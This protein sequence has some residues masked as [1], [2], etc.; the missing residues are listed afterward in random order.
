MRQGPTSMHLEIVTFN[1]WKMSNLKYNN[2]VSIKLLVKNADSEP[3]CILFSQLH[4][5]LI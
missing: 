3:H 2:K 4:I 1:S 5:K